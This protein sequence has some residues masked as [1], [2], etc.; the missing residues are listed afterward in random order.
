MPLTH[1]P[2]TRRT[3]RLLRA[4]TVLAALPL[5]LSACGSSSKAGV[6]AQ[7]AASGS[8]APAAA[9]ATTTGGGVGGASTVCA[10]VAGASLVALTDDKKLQNSDNI[11][12]VVTTTVAKPP[13]T[14]GLNKVSAALTQSALV[15]LNKSFDVDG[16]KSADIASSFVKDNSLGSGL[17]GGSG[18]ITVV[19]ASFSEN[20]TVANIYADVLTAAGY[21]AKVKTLNNRELYLPQLEKGSVQ[22]VPEYAAT[23]T[24]FLADAKKDTTDVPSPDI[25]T[26]IATL[27]TLA[28]PVG[29]TVLDPAAATD[30][31]AFAVTTAFAAKYG[32]KTLSD[33]ATTCGGGLTLGGPA[34][35]PTRPFCQLGLQKTYGLVVTGFTALDAGGPLSKNALKGGKVA[36]ALVFSSDASLSAG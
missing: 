28:T 19:A 8:S 36:L 6:Q 30:E 34:E 21:Q 20:I 1:T 7:P 22:V 24:Q 32:V 13:L 25:I 23:L 29:L 2:T 11:V 18:P 35:C 15:D 26:T 5:A 27:K 31:N 10:P 17:S 3:V 33:L 4:A 16:L 9:G 12:P 14:D